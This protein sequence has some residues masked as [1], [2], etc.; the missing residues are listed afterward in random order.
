MTARWI[1]HAD[2]DAFY[3]SVEQRECPELR[4]KPV[5]VGAHSARGV[6]SA[7][8][9]EAREYGVHSAMPGFRARELCPH[10][11]FLPGRM[12]LYA[13][14]SA[15]VHE[16]F[17]TFTPLIQPLA[18]DE[19]FL[20]VSGSMHFYSGP[21]AL[22]RRIKSEVKA[23][24]SLNVSVGVATNK[25]VAKVACTLGKPNGL[26]VVAPGSEAA[27]LAPLPI[28][29]L[30]GVG[31]VTAEKLH[32]VGV[33]TISDLAS[34]AEARLRPVVGQRAAQFIAWA[35]GQDDSPVESRGVPKSCGEE[36]TF[37]SDVTDRRE[38][39]AALTAHAEMVAS[40]LRAASLRGRTITLKI[41]LGARA[42]RRAPR[43]PGQPGEPTYP[44][45]SR[46]RSLDVATHD[47]KQIRDVALSLWDAAGVSEPVRLLGVSVS[48][49]CRSDEPL[50]L[51]L[52]G[53]RQK[54]DRLG[55]AL[56]EIRERFGKGAIRRAVD[57]PEK[58]T[59]SLH[60]KT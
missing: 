37:A 34:M 5:I 22:G 38:V 13:E 1:V 36:N 21:E 9:Y 39:S 8:S 15:K 17:E 46:S 50:Q 20:D 57:E 47:G 26:E 12:E 19:A 29:K 2:M 11:V 25:L 3:A 54:A 28:R 42:G 30:W 59:I 24:T 45:L 55:P 53:R 7:A 44:L 4:G 41:K 31:P 6:V 49:L 33:R 35:Q 16:V 27:L 52:F 43:V 51:D 14:V 18:L 23:R 56:D 10:G 58:T 60:R 32:S 48:N 40:R